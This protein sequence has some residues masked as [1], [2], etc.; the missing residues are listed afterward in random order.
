MKKIIP[1][2]P[3]HPGEIVLEELLKTNNITI[4]QLAKEINMPI[5][6]I[7]SFLLKKVN[8]TS[9]FIASLATYFKINVNFFYSLQ[10]SY[11]I[12]LLR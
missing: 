5:I 4:E 1:I 12:S 7:N 6:E 2:H 11:Q 9:A 10:N 8:F 3:T